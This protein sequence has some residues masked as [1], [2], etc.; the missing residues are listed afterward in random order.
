MLQAVKAHLFIRENVKKSGF[1]LVEVVVVSALILLVSLVGFQT[2]DIVAQRE[3]EERL[4]YALLEMRA[5]MDL[6]HQEQLRFPYSF[7]ELINTP[8]PVNGSNYG[9]YLRRLPLNPIFATTRW[10]ISSK[11]SRA[12]V[13]DV[14]V[15]ITLPTAIIGAFPGEPIVDVRCPEPGYTSL[16]GD[17]YTVW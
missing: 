15:P 7:N 3:K 16:R 5:A 9:Y 17:P 11:T 14:W 1:T 4:R 10:E 13:T 12:G 8:R 6:F 2:A